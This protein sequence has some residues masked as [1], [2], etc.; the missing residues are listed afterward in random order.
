M[1]RL[2]VPVLLCVPLLVWLSVGQA[3]KQ[4]DVRFLVNRRAGCHE[5]NYYELAKQ[6]S[7]LGGEVITQ[8]P[9]G[10]RYGV[11]SIWKVRVQRITDS[12][13]DPESTRDSH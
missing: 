2:R 9:Q 6:V 4:D 13:K 11:H 7:L 3:R 8:E 10:I 1:I 12:Q 5:K